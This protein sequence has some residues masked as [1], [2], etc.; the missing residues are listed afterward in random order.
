[1]SAPVT[2]W[3]C[4]GT[5]VST[6]SVSAAFTS[7]IQPSR[8]VM[9]SLS[10]G[11]LTSFVPQTMSV[12]GVMASIARNT[13]EISGLPT[14]T[15]QQNANSQM[16]TTLPVITAVVT[17]TGMPNAITN[18]AS[19]VNPQ[20]NQQPVGGST[21]LGHFNSQ[22]QNNGN[23]TQQQ[24]QWNHPTQYPTQYQTSQQHVMHQQQQYQQ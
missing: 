24:V 8:T 16:N 9:T 11:T 15:G 5:V 1:M 3:S 19:P 14:Q 21:V 17:G 7:S 4:A 22:I 23:Q 6:A 18:S 2:T 10:S 20:L 12:G 13:S